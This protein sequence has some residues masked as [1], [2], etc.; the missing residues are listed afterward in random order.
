MITTNTIDRQ[1]NKVLQAFSDLY[2]LKGTL[3]PICNERNYNTDNVVLC[4]QCAK[5]WDEVQKE[6]ILKKRGIK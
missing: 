6:M 5:A 2:K 1:F 3:C 4:P